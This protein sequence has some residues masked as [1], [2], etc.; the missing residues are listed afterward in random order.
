MIIKWFIANMSIDV[1]TDLFHQVVSESRQMK[2][3]IGAD[4]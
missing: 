2:R 3:K 4:E 1:E